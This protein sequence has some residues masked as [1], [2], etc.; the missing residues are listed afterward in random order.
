[1]RQI[2]NA[3]L[4]SHDSSLGVEL[5]AHRG[6]KLGLDSKRSVHEVEGSTLRSGQIWLFLSGTEN[7]ELSQI[8]SF[9]YL[10]I[11]E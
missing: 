6:A 4:R 9:W 3:R 7:R 1:M 5:C 2:F 11:A 10:T 8:S